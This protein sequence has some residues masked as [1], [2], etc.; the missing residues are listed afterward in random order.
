MKKLLLFAAFAIVCIA[1][2]SFA[3]DPD[4]DYLPPNE[5][6]DIYIV[7]KYRDLLGICGDTTVWATWGSHSTSDTHKPP[8]RC[9]TGPTSGYVVKLKH[10]KKDSVKLSV[11]SDGAI[12][13]G[14]MQGD[15]PW[16]YRSWPV[17]SWSWW[18]WL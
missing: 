8:S 10:S 12:I 5:P 14:P 15:L 1:Q 3:D 6:G 13:Y 17:D 7:V 2:T 11:S 18:T 4:T 16:E 9:F